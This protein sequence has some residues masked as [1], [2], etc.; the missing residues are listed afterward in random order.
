MLCHGTDRPRHLLRARGH[1][2]D[3]GR[4]LVSAGRNAAD[5]RLGGAHGC[6]HVDEAVGD[7]L[8]V[9][10]ESRD[11]FAHLLERRAD[12]LE[13]RG[14]CIAARRHAA[15][16]RGRLNHGGQKLLTRGREIH[17]VSAYVADRPRELLD[18]SRG[19]IRS[20]RRS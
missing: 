13:R 11:P 5:R 9:A 3:R 1:L 12:L 6:R 20:L 17:R 18:G 7:I 4:E 14:V 10:G 8:R 19:A 2:L 15:D 16:A